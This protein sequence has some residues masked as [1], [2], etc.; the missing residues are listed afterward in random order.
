MASWL[1]C[2]I[3]GISQNAVIWSDPENPSQKDD[4]TIFFDASE[5]NGELAGFSGDVYTHTGVI[6][7]RSNNASDWQHV[8][9]NWGTH[10]A[11][12]LMK[13]EQEENI[14]SI[15]FN[16]EA[17][18]G[19][20]ADEV[21]SQLAFVFRNASGSLVGRNFDGSDIFL[22]LAPPGDILVGNLLSPLSQ[23]FV[24]FMG[25]SILLEYQLNKIAQITIMDNDEVIYAEETDQV[26]F[27][28]TPMT[29]IGKHTMTIEANDGSETITT[30]ID[31]F[32]IIEN[33]N[34]EDPP[35]TVNGLNYYSDSSYIFQFFAPEK[36][37]AYLLASSNGFA[38]DSTFQMNRSLDSHTFWIE[39]PK[40]LFENG[41][42]TYQYMVDDGVVVADPYSTIVLDPLNDSGIESS[43]RM[44]LPS[45]PDGASGIVTAFDPE[46]AFYQW[47]D[48]DF[49]RPEKSQ[50]I[51]YELLLRDFLTSHSY[52][53]LVDTLSYLEKLGVN[54]IELMPIGEFEG[55]QSW[56]Y[57]PSFHMAVDKYYGSRD[58]LKTFINEA[59]KRNIAVILD[60]V[61]NHA[62]SQ[63]PLA[64]LYWNEKAF[65]PHPDNPWLNVTARHPFNVGYDFNHESQATKDWVK[66]ILS[67]WIE[68]FHFDGFRFDL[69]KGLTQTN[70]GTD[71]ALM[72]RY[73]PSRVAILG[74]Y[75][76]HIW[77]IDSS[78]YVIL[79][80]FADNTEERILADMGMLLWGNMNHE[81]SEAVMGY[82]SS[83]EWGD[84]TRRGFN[85]PHL[86]TYLESHDE[87][88]LM[89][90]IPRYGNSSGAYSTRKLE[91]A[92]DRMAAASTIFYTIPGPKMLWQFG[93]LGYDNSINRCTN[94]SI[95]N[96]CR[97]DPKPAGWNLLEDSDRARL[98]DITKALI[99][100]RRDYPTF[101]STDFRLNDLDPFVKAV[102]LDHQ[103]M[104]AVALANFNV[105]EEPFR[106]NFPYPGTWHEFFTGDSLLVS[107]TN[108]EL[109]LAPGDYRLYTSDRISSSDTL[110]TNS[111][112]IQLW[113]EAQIFP[114]PSRPGQLLSV[115]LPGDSP[116]ES[117][118]LSSLEGIQSHVAFSSN[119]AGIQFELSSGLPAGIYLI[120]INVASGRRYRARLVVL[121]YSD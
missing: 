67:Y 95:D 72:S 31:Y 74:D 25:D 26:S 85:E 80:H 5:G 76:Q 58:Q 11:R 68:E 92:L 12:V 94:G 14:Y 19:I 41:Q 15:S 82:T 93:E 56:G 91:T 77:S 46:P 44:T 96:D 53:D 6:T 7:N 98:F 87:E 78:I 71:E 107:D 121:D 83:L 86:I 106:A 75:A 116:V 118:I 30:S 33:E 65:R 32:L 37:Y 29:E 64:Q 59:H 50:L 3:L 16:I 49:K 63:S 101:S 52:K 8:I 20:P 55:N 36:S 105:I 111:T 35:G 47:T 28:F 73:D 79:E 43:V 62:F 89:Y 18:Y 45:Y 21:V 97:L 48:A 100:L 4:V 27:Y 24:V 40:P 115:E 38:P 2:W 119:S 113:Q 103:A 34:S 81:Y 57:N 10:D 110:A 102:Y 90:K 60:V 66:Q 23:N 61:F 114:N 99:G 39:L 13:K 117:I 17:F 42:S 84:Y 69:S 22:E 109:N 112:Q 9:G 88:R 120:R 70:S 51:I 108:L 104:D 1:T 54:A